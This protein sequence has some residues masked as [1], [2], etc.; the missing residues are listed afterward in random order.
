MASG[1]QSETT[2]LTPSTSRPWKRPTRNNAGFVLSLS[3]LVGPAF[4]ALLP[5][6]SE[7]QLFLD[8]AIVDSTS[9]TRRRLN[10]ARKISGNPVI[11]AD[12][13]WEGPDCRLSWV[14]FD[15]RL[16]KFRM[17]YST[18][19][20]AAS[21]RKPDGTVNLTEGARVSCEAFSDDGVHWTKP[22]LG[23][24]EF[25]GS[26]E[27]NIVP[28]EMA[29]SYFFQDL[30]D[31]DPARRYKAHIRTGDVRKPGM[32]FELLCSPDGYQWTRHPAPTVDLKEHVGRWG[33]TH[34]LGWDPI[35]ECYA[36]H[37][38]NNL[39]MNSITWPRR[40]IG[41]AESRDLQSWSASETIVRVDD[42]DFPDTEFYAMPT[43]FVER[44]YVSFLWNFSTN[45]TT[46]WPELA[47]SRDGLRYEREFRQPIIA[48]GDTGDFDSVCVYAEAPLV[49]GDKVFC[50]YTGT[51]WRSP[52]QLL[53]IGDKARAGVGLAILRRDG[54]VSYEGGRVEPGVVTTRAFAFSGNALY[55]NLAAALQEWGAGPCEVRVALLDERHS[56]IPGF[57]A[58]DADVISTS[59]PDRRVT[60]RGKGDVSAL[61]GRPV[62]LQI[63]FTNSKIY[64][65]QF[66][67]T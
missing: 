24:A 48:L 10:P 41:R 23:L 17:R 6:G 66:R 40:S 19:R 57:T 47:V 65:F 63:Q 42:R 46:I 7:R 12:R 32:K 49:H 56:P 54:F 44:H 1:F 35:R 58:D 13:A 18:G 5:I 39:H 43:A 14:I 8:D 25:Q 59:D 4:A 61:A 20:Y 3:L 31:P 45:N 15:H 51:N 38:E 27:N 52:E 50:Y 11:A 16:G 9:H 22:S 53:A 2:P 37:M 29:H 36:A 30:H 34:F 55:L 26:R 67:Q 60:W 62:R 21:G 33:P 28:A 64:A